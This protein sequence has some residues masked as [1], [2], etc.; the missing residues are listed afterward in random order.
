MSEKP[1]RESTLINPQEC[2]IC[3]GRDFEV[4]ISNTVFAKGTFRLR[5]NKMMRAV[6][7]L[8]CNYVMSFVDEEFTRRNNQ[9]VWL[10]V[11]FIIAF[12]LCAIIA[13]LMVISN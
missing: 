1:K 7:C 2:P 5:G 10:I 9:R 8:N 3:G 11:G 4:G 6:R 13:A 12:Y